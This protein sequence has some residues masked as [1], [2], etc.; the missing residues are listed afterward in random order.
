M[1]DQRV[2]AEKQNG[3]GQEPLD[4]LHEAAERILAKWRGVM[5]ENKR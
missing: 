4:A 2:A 3:V 5:A 1:V